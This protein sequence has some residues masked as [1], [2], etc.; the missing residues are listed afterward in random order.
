MGTLLAIF[1]WF[2]ITQ[3]VR[4]FAK[5]L[6]L[7]QP[8][9]PLQPLQLLQHLQPSTGVTAYT[10][11]AAT[12]FSTAYAVQVVV[13]VLPSHFNSKYKEIGGQ[14]TWGSSGQSLIDFH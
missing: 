7:L 4:T 12:A 13:L 1:E 9:Q 8:P 2:W 6:Q 5:P 14:L 11:L 3:V 10:A